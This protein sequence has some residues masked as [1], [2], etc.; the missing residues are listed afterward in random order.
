[1]TPKEYEVLTGIPLSTIYKQLRAGTIQAHKEPYPGSPDR[2][3][4]DEPTGASVP[5]D[6]DPLST[7]E[8]EPGETRPPFRDLLE[9][10]ESLRNLGTTRGSVSSVI[11]MMIA[12]M[13]AIII[14]A[15][16]DRRLRS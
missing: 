2:W 1:M 15:A 3:V 7:N 10:P 8:E 14:M 4:I 6:V 5:D 11:W 16:M 13:A 9:D 12:W